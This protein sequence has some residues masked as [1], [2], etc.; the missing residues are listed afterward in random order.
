[1]TRVIGISGKI[2]SG[3]D[4]LARHLAA[5]LTAHGFATG[6]ASFAFPLK[7]ML[8]RILDTLRAGQVAGDAERAQDFKIATDF[9][10]P[11]PKAQ[12]LTA[13]LRPDLAE[14]A[15]LNAYDRTPGVRSALQYLGTDVF[16]AEDPNY[17]VK[18]F[19]GA[20]DETQDF[21]FVTDVRFPNEADSIREVG[22]YMIRLEVPAEIILDRT[23]NRDGLVYTAEQLSHP[24]ETALDG[25]GHFDLTVGSDFSATAIVAGFA[26][27]G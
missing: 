22:G 4:Y 17:W 9:G 6:S 7:D 10:I 12:V 11:Y 25:Y 3:K 5:E 21:V 18:L 19:H 15:D 20:L 1:M 13:Y 14:K 24:S 16:R 8:N 2:G 26:P 27:L 23:L